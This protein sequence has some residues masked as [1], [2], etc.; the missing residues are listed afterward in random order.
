MEKKPIQ[1]STI[2][3]GKR[4]FFFDIN[5][6]SNNKKYLKITESKFVTEGDEKKRTS[7]VL[8]PEDVENFKATLEQVTK[9]LQN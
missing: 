4:M 6:S 1:T 5:L 8:F 9:H 3:S 2:K 7:F